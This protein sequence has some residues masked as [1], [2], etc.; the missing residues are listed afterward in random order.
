MPKS[1]ERLTGKPFE[2][3]IFKIYK[4]LEP[5]ATIIKNDMIMGFETSTKREIDISIRQK[6]ADHELLIII[7]A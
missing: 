4:E 1:K 3:L 5:H 2:D 7:Q 6:I